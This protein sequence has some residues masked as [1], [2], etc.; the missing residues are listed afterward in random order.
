[1]RDSSSVTT[2]DNLISDTT[3]FEPFTEPTSN[4]PFSAFRSFD[5]VDSLSD[6]SIPSL[7]STFTSSTGPF[8]DSTDN[9]LFADTTN[10]AQFADTT[11]NDQFGDTISN[12]P[13]ADTG[14]IPFTDTASNLR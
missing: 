4:D 9:N 5:P 1:M 6:N 10:N 7:F 14:N 2:H 12:N 8:I 3:M 11:M 13:F